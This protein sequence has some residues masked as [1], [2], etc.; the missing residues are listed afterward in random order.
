MAGA[1]YKLFA[2]GDVLT[3]A[4]VN[5]YLNEQTVMVFASS[6]ARTSALSG[7]LAEGMMS[8]LQDTNAVEVYNGT[9]WVNV[10]NA[11]DITEVQAGVGISI[12]SGTG[13][14][15]VIT[16]SSTDLIT[17]AGDLLYGTAADTVARLGIGAAGR[18]LKVNSGATAPEWAVDPT[19]DVVT[20]AGDL[21]YGTAADTVARL[22]IGTAGQV[23]K[24][25]SGA[26]A[27]E[28]GAAAGGSFVGCVVYNSANQ[29]LANSTEVKITFNSESLDTD[30]FH[31]TSSNTSRITIPAGK[32]GKYLFFAFGVFVNNANG[33][34]Q[35]QMWKN[36]DSTTRFANFTTVGNSTS[37]TYGNLVGVIDLV[38]TDYVELIAYQNSGGSLDFYGGAMDARFGCIYLGA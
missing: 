15:P 12:A 35:L 5:T 38:A 3:A 18:V 31:S 34:R 32:G 7:V 22:G 9:A 19:T 8:Y 20:T 33:Y 27:P 29:S 37:T 6:A 1:G 21:I 25:N 16:N 36:N 14:I 17:T 11:G 30:S 24:V 26:T 2:T 28:W 4:Q 10:G 23:L 13:P